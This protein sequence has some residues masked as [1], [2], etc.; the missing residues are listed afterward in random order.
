MLRSGNFFVWFS[1]AEQREKMFCSSRAFCL[2]SLF[3]L[4]FSLNVVQLEKYFSSV[5]RLIWKHKLVNSVQLRKRKNKERKKL[6]KSAIILNN[7]IN[8]T[9]VQVQVKF[10]SFVEES[11]DPIRWSSSLRTFLKYL[12]PWKQKKKNQSHISMS[13]VH[14]IPINT[15]MQFSMSFYEF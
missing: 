3:S 10:W 12:L 2:Y 14:R 9:I 6:W 1:L 5:N 15:R 8:E 4:L 13:I 7:E 11:M